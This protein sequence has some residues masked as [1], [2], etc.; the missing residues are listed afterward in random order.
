MSD[1]GFRQGYPLWVRM[2]LWLSVVLAIACGLYGCWDRR[3]F[4]GS[5]WLLAAFWYGLTIRWVDQ[6][7]QWHAVG[8]PTNE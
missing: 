6:H 3:F 7:G 1:T 4:W 8:R 2:G 5:L